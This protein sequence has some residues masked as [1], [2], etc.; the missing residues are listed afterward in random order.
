M[1]GLCLVLRKGFNA[2]SKFLIKK[3]TVKSIITNSIKKQDYEQKLK[4]NQSSI[5]MFFW[6]KRNKFFKGEW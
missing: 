2:I 6:K 3:K 4:L 5:E 1:I